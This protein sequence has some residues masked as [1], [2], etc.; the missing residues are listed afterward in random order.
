MSWNHHTLATG[1]RDRSILLRDVRAAEPYVQKLNGHRSEVCGLR[2]SPDD[3]ELASGGNDNQLCVWHQHSVQP[4]LRFTEHQAAVKAIAW[5][6]HQHGLL[7]SGG[8]TADRCIRFWNTTTGQPLQCIDTG[9]QVGVWC[10]AC[11]CGVRAAG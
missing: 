1:S 8:G 11:W 10:C 5:S 6:P 3:R 9:S 7:V 2:W 4:V